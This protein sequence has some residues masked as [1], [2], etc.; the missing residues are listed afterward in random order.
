[1]QLIRKRFLTPKAFAPWRTSFNLIFLLS[2]YFMAVKG[3]KISLSSFSSSFRSLL[4]EV[5]FTTIDLGTE[6][7]CSSVSLTWVFV[8][9]LLEPT[10]GIYKGPKLILYKWPKNK[11]NH[12]KRKLKPILKWRS[13]WETFRV[14]V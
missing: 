9:F 7:I 12:P 1:M 6:S 8:F 13:F 2:L 3:Y 4:N 14:S 11:E 5:L 10:L